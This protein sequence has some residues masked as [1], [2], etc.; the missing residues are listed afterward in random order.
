MDEAGVLDLQK[1]FPCL[2]VTPQASYWTSPARLAFPSLSAPRRPPVLGAKPKYEAVLLFPPGGAPKVLLQ[3]VR[4]LASNSFGTDLVRLPWR[5]QGERAGRAGYQEGG[6]YF[7]AKSDA[8]PELL[9]RDGESCSP[10]AFYSGCWVR[11]RVQPFPYSYGWEIAGRT[12]GV[13]LKLLALQFLA[14]DEDLTEAHSR[15]TLKLG[16]DAGPA[17]EFTTSRSR[18]LEIDLSHG[19]DQL[20]V[21]LTPEEAEQ[22]RKFLDR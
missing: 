11:C 17:V 14:D 13:G 10:N 1:S 9:N 22:L 12:N 6:M 16:T 20:S 8:R 7:T 18:G 4:D 3:A 19:G 5:D 21:A 2:E 15:R